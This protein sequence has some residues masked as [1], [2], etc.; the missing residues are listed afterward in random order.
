MKSFVGCGI[1]YFNSSAKG[2]LIHDKSWV[3]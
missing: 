2:W 1:I 3:W